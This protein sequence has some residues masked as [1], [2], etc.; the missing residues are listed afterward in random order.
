LNKHEEKEASHLHLPKTTVTKHMLYSTYAP[1]LTKAIELKMVSQVL[2]QKKL[3]EEE[4]EGMEKLDRKILHHPLQL[5][6]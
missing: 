3:A 6:D 1:A 4:E 2:K 5:Q